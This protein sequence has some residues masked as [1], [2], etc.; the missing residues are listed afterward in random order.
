M[1]FLLLLGMHFV[2]NLCGVQEI[3]E[4]RTYVEVDPRFVLERVMLEARCMGYDFCVKADVEFASGRS[5]SIPFAAADSVADQI[6]NMEHLCKEPYTKMKIYFYLEDIIERKNVF[7]TVL[8]EENVSCIA[9]QFIDGIMMRH[10]SFAACDNPYIVFA[11]LLKSGLQGIK[12]GL[13]VHTS[14][15]L[16]VFDDGC[17]IVERLRDVSEQAV[18]HMIESDFMRD[19]LGLDVLQV[20]AD[21]KLA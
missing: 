6:I 13:D 12:C 9:Q 4:L 1:F 15:G 7:K 5:L 2:G 18:I 21:S 3:H 14:C 10:N 17:F 8:P 19:W 11:A 16:Y 20:Y